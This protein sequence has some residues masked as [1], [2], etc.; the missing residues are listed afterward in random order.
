MLDD[1]HIGDAE[2]EGGTSIML[3]SQPEN[4]A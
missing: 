4:A 3:Q 2:P 1:L